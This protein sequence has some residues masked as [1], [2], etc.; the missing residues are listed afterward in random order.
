M[1]NSKVIA[2]GVGLSAAVAGGWLAASENAKTEAAGVE[3]QQEILHKGTVVALGNVADGSCVTVTVPRLTTGSRGNQFLH[4][5]TDGLRV[6]GLEGSKD[7][8]SAKLGG[9][10]AEPVALA[11]VGTE[12]GAED[13]VQAH[14]CRAGKSAV[15]V[16]VTFGAGVSAADYLT[17][18]PT[19][20]A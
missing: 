2:A 5:T 11:V 1:R 7:H 8:L 20:R 4:R 14:L 19:S 9:L 16:H 17:A 10:E 18:I 13:E 6:G 15:T 12:E 3:L